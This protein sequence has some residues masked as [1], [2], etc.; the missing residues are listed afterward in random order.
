M[1]LPAGPSGHIV[2]SIS[3]RFEIQEGKHY[4]PYCCSFGLRNIIRIISPFFLIMNNLTYTQ[5]FDYFRDYFHPNGLV[6][7][8]L[9]GRAFPFTTLLVYL[10]L[11]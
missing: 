11:F 4:A 6:G 9:R 5:L 8:G 7:C 3:L 1:Y 2:S 10:V